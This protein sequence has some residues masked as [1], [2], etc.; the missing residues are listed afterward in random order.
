MFTGL[1]ETTGTIISRTISN[2]AG[3]FIIKPEKTFKNLEYGESIAVNGTCLT[4][5]TTTSNGDITFH[6]LEETCKKSNIGSLPI[7]SVVNLER[8]LAVGDRLGGH[9]VQGHVDTTAV[10]KNIGRSGSDFEIK[11]ELPENLK[12]FMIPKGS[13]TI[14][15]VSLTIVQL[16]DSYFTVNIIPVTLKETALHDRKRGDLV[17]L[18]TDIIGKYVARQQSLSD[19]S[20]LDMNTLRNA[21]W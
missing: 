9:L 1:V 2:G 8:A 5:E 4:L 16:E 6:V 11:I 12:P 13:I 19:K 10:I 14:D 21:G 15:G 3:K 20:N 18:E 17:N 7:G